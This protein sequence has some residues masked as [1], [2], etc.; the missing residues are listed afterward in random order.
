MAK[1]AWDS[2]HQDLNED[3]LW[4]APTCC[5]FFL[6]IP[7]LILLLTGKFGLLRQKLV[8]LTHVNTSL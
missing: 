3:K 5:F 1:L 4:N 7:N 2:L 6:D 8:E